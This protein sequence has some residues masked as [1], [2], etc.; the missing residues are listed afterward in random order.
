LCTRRRC[1]VEKA[2][3]RHSGNTIP[4]TGSGNPGRNAAREI[5]RDRSRPTAIS[6]ALWGPLTWSPP[7]TETFDPD[8]HLGLPGWIYSSPGFFA[9]E[10]ERVLAPSWQVVCHISDIPRAGDFQ[11]FDFIGESI[12]VIRGRDGFPRVFSSLPSPCLDAALTGPPVSA[13]AS[14]VP[15]MPGPM[16]WTPVHTLT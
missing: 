10:Q 5:P 1:F 16:I 9:A 14:C 4:R 12:V 2:V 7:M 6:L 15:T 11:I 8:E 3:I 13:A